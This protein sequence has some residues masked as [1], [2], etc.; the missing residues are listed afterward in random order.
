M[1]ERDRD[2]ASESWRRMIAEVGADLL[3]IV[4]AIEENHDQIETIRIISARYASRSERRRYETAKDRA[5]RT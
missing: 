2:I 3:F 5:L 4:Y 1:D